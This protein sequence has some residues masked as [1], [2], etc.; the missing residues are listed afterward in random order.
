MLDGIG[1]LLRGF[2]GFGFLSLC[3]RFSMCVE[4]VVFVSSGKFGIER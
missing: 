4:K 2:V 3:F 1:I